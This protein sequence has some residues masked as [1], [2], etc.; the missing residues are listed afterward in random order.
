VTNG[1]QIIDSY[2]ELSNSTIQNSLSSEVESGFFNLMIG[3]RLLICDNTVI[4][5]ITAKLY[6]LMLAA[7]DSEVTIAGDIKIQDVI[8]LKSDS[9]II[10]VSNSPNVTIKDNVHIS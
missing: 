4:Q 3:S 8:S 5:N 9:A 7:T 1:I 6:G 2:L 10:D